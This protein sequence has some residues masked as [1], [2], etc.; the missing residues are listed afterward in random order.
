[1]VPTM[2][3]L[4]GCVTERRDILL[5]TRLEVNAAKSIVMVGRREVVRYSESV[6]VVSV[7][8]QYRLRY[9]YRM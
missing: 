9:V 7:G 8:K 6:S 4:C 2:K 5:G 3:E 1:M